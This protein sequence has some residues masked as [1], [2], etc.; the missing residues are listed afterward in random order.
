[1]QT[2]PNGLVRASFDGRLGRL[3]DPVV[4]SFSIFEGLD[5]ETALTTIAFMFGN[6]NP[7]RLNLLGMQTCLLALYG[8]GASVS[9]TRQELWD[10]SSE[11]RRF[12]ELY[13]LMEMQDNP[14][15]K[16]LHYVFNEAMKRAA[17]E[18]I[19]QGSRGDLPVG[20]K[21]LRLKQQTCF[22]KSDEDLRAE[23]RNIAF[24]SLHPDPMENN[25]QAL[26]VAMLAIWAA[27]ASVELTEAQYAELRANAALQAY[28]PPLVGR[29]YVCRVRSA[30]KVIAAADERAGKEG[31]LPVGS[32]PE[33][34][35]GERIQL[36]PEAAAAV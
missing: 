8:A 19:P 30:Q 5:R 22:T 14:N 2:I 10:L 17:R 36:E 13:S 9:L 21:L 34:S 20:F 23:L 33:A 16:V 7:R 6:N 11:L 26:S 1:M 18:A 24:S 32:A 35:R 31:I 12:Q 29:A 3:T 28:A 4:D 25:L 27:G 15:G